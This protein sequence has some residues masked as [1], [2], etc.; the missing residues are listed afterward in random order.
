MSGL[1]GVSGGPYSIAAVFDDLQAYA[2]DLRRGS[3]SLLEQGAVASR[4]VW[5]PA[6]MTADLLDP[7]GAM[8]VAAEAMAVGVAVAAAEAL[9]TQLATSLTAAATAYRAVDETQRRLTEV[10]DAARNLPAT[11]WELGHGDWSEAIAADPALTGVGVDGLSML[12]TRAT[13]GLVVGVPAGAAVFG[14]LYQDGQPKVTANP[15][16]PTADRNGPPRGAKD[17]IAGLAVRGRHDAGGGA[18]DVRTLSSH[19][20]AG[21]PVK[22]AIVD[23]T[24]TTRWNGPAGRNA[25]VSDLGTNFKA[26]AN[27]PS[28]Y[29]RGVVEAMKRAGV[30]PNDPVMIVG[31]S[32]GGMVGAQ[33]ASELSKSKQFNVTHLVTAGSPISLA[34]VPSS[35]KTLSLENAHDFVPHLDGVGNPA[36]KNWITA[37]I[38]E[39][40]H[41]CDSQ[42][43]LDSYEKGAAAVDA[44]DDVNL[45]SWR[46]DASVFL[47]ADSV[48]TEVFQVR[49]Q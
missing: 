30:G 44:S 26:M 28:S 20:A 38:D 12:L 27:E 23:I 5:D 49:R 37:E 41:D 17:L 40:S 3:A 19:D 10:Y 45:E 13:G 35:V 21:R 39:G 31:H 7:L 42:H 34:T 46:Q 18:I 29:G 8:N 36:H 48:R 22:A 4:A 2:G 15:G 9:A 47:N 25:Q 11:A 32:Q 6:M 1:V 24:G 33:L 16:A 14:R 43:S